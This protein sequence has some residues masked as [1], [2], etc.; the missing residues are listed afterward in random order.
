MNCDLEL[1]YA[2]GRGESGIFVYGIFSH[3]APYGPLNV[4]ESRFIT[5]IN[6][7]FDWISVDADRNMLQCAPRDWAG[8]R[9]SMN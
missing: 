5:K 7:T 2:L 4:P 9:R 8:E 3:P 1:R 6:Q